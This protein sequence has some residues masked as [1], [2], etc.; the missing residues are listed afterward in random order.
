MLRTFFAS[1]LYSSTNTWWLSSSSSS[2]MAPMS[3][4]DEAQVVLLRYARRSVSSAPSLAAAKS[5]AVCD[6]MKAVWGREKV[7]SETR[8]L[9]LVVARGKEE[10]A[11]AQG[12]SRAT[13]GCLPLEDE[14]GAVWWP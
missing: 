3:P 7:C 5:R 1:R 12:E 6:P 4:L 13:A 2:V 14:D 9:G 11:G 8:G 10:D